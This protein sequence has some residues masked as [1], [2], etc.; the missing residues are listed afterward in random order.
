MNWIDVYVRRHPIGARVI[1]FGVFVVLTF[2]QGQFP[3][4]GQYWLYLAKVIAGGYLLWL[5]RGALA[6]LQW[7]F[8]GAAL[9]TGVGVFVLWVGLY[10]FLESLG[11]KS[12]FARFKTSGPAWNPFATFG[13][14]APLAWIFVIV[15]LAGSGLL[16]PM[17]EEIFFRSFLYRYL[18]KPDFLS[19]SL[20]TF[21][22]R[23]FFIASIIFGFEH[24]EWLAGILTGFI[25]QGLVLWKG[26]L[27]DAITAHAIT[28]LLLGGWVVWK[29]AWEFW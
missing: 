26:R 7:K 13:D 3:S 1:P 18:E 28:N 16:V 17:L 14:S 4:P 2:L 23:A 25:Y 19:V 5:A 21:S 12:S 11:I 6:E 22:A 27:G 24:G 10:P 15:R 8:S 29:G 9:A 20:R